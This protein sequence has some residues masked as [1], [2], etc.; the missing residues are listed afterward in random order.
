MT[1]A[2]ETRTGLPDALRVLVAEHPRNGWEN[3]PGFD[4]LIQFWLDRHIMFRRVLAQMTSQTQSLLDSKLDGM[5]FG[6]SL[7]RYGGM[8]VNGLHEHHTVEDQHYFPRLV[9][10]D[11]RVSKGFDILE[12]DHHALDRH[13]SD[14]VEKANTTLKSLQN[15]TPMRNAAGGLHDQ[16]DLLSRLLDRHLTDEEELIVPIILVHGSPD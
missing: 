8:F 14:F 10:K 7:S 11:S 5:D 16:L 6:R 13:L 2:L 3:D 12:K 4:A 9:G 1:L 15:P